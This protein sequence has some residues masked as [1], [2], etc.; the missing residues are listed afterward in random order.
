MNRTDFLLRGILKREKFRFAFA[1]ISCTLTDGIKIHDTD[2]VA[3][4]V[5]AEALASATLL[6]PLLEG[7]ERYSVRWEYPDGLVKG[8]LADVNAQGAVRG[9]IKEPY[10]MDKTETPDGDDIYGKEDGYISIVKSVNGKILNS[11]RTRA[12][13]ASPAADTGF[14]FSVSD[15]LETEIVVATSFNADTLKPVKR[16]CGMLL[17]AMPDCN[18]KELET[19][20]KRM[21]TPE[22]KELLLQEMP[23]EKQLWTLLSYIAGRKNTSEIQANITYEFAPSPEFKCS[24]S[25]EKMREAMKTLGKAELKKIFAESN[26]TPQITCQFCH[27]KYRFQKADF[28]ELLK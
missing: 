17:Q 4:G 22:F 1:D 20:R 3:S 25:Q 10:I 12:A 5:L 7:N 26:E 8:L 9:L 24:C 28:A 14:F 2:P 23:L 13:L 21:N 6:S 15:Q 16:C 11:G 19:Y 27:K 18:L